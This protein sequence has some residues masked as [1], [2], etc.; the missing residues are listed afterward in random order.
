MEYQKLLIAI[1]V[2]VGVYLLMTIAL[3][4]SGNLFGVTFDDMNVTDEELECAR[5]HMCDFNGRVVGGEVIPY[6]SVENQQAVSACVESGESEADCVNR[7]GCECL[8]DNCKPDLD[9][10]KCRSSNWRPSGPSY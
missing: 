7:L 9:V 1:A 6:G 3:S 4:K 8:R 10:K 2:F 5:T